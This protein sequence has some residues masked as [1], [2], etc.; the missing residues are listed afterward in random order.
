MS[1]NFTVYYVLSLSKSCDHVGPT[2]KIY[3]FLFHS[4]IVSPLLRFTFLITRL[5]SSNFLA[6][7]STIYRARSEHLNRY[8]T[9]A[10]SYNLISNNNSYI[11]NH[12]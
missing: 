8:T 9:D 4:A 2:Y 3:F 12:E 1:F 6:F 10:D 11:K 7:L 5:V